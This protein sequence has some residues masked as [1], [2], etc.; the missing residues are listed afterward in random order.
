MTLTNDSTFGKGGDQKERLRV[1]RAVRMADGWDC[2]E[3][4]GRLKMEKKKMVA[5]RNKKRNET[6]WCVGWWK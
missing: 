3:E 2:G 1:V 5:E 6:N 4:R